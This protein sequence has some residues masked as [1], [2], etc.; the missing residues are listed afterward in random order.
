MT[1]PVFSSIDLWSDHVRTCI[2]LL[3]EALLL[4]GDQY[5]DADENSLNRELYKTLIRVSHRVG[6]HIAHIPP[7][8]LDGRNLP[9]PSDPHQT[10]REFKRPDIYWPYIDNLAADENDACKQFVVECKRLT[11]P[12]TRY[13]REYVRSGIARFID[14]DHSYGKGMQSGAM[15]GYLQKVLLDDALTRINSIAVTES[16]PPLDIRHRNGETTAEY[17]HDLVRGYPISPFR[18]THL[19]ARVGQ[20]STV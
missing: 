13:A 2:E 18:L 19:W 6:Q 17:E 10:P 3:R 7:A 4:L 12:S 11:S 5:L 15:V 9:V 14:E 8:V 16:V 1:R 20:H